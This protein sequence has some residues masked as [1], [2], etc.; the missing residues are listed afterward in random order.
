MRE[1]LEALLAAELAPNIVLQVLPLDVGAHASL[2]GPLTI[3]ETKRG[4]TL[5]YSE[6]RS[7]AEYITD[8]PAVAEWRLAFN[9]LRAA[10]LS[11]TESVR[12]V[13]RILE[14]KYR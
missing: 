6:S 3:L 4:T 2:T 9:M 5:G 13:S 14:D 1:Q 7:S 8:P 12:H 10:A 11:P